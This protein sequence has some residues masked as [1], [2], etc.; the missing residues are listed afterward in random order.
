M[1]S[2]VKIPEREI[3]KLTIANNPHI[4]QGIVSLEV[5]VGHVYMHLIESASF[6]IGRNKTY[7]GVPKKFGCFCLQ[8][9]VS[10]RWSRLC[11]ICCRN[12]TNR[13]LHR[14]F[15]CYSFWRTFDG[16]YDTSSLKI[17]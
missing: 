6:N 15:G 5:K 17:N 14:K 13:P 8:T 3:Y 12:K 7:Y 16:D 11:F 10:K 9:F 4:I 2:A 1:A